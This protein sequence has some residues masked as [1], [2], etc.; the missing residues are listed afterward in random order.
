MVVSLSCGDPKTQEELELKSHTGSDG[1]DKML[2]IGTRWG[3]GLLMCVS[4]MAA[5]GQ[6]NGGT[7]TTLEEI[8]VT[9]QKREQDLRE[10][11]LAVSTLSGDAISALSLVDGKELANHLPGLSWA[12][13]ISKP[14][15][16]IRGVGNND[17]QSSSHNP[18]SLYAD[19]VLLGSS[20]G[21]SNIMFDL[22]RVEVLKGPQGTLWGR[23]TTAGLINF[24]PR[25]AEIGGE[26]SGSVSATGGSFSFREFDSAV[27][28][29]LSENSAIR[30]AYKHSERDG[31]Y[32][33]VNP[34]Y[35]FST[36]AWNWTAGRINFRSQLTDTTILDITGYWG[37]LENE[38]IP[39]KNLG[40]VGDCPNPGVVGTTCGDRDGFVN[41]PD[42]YE[43]GNGFETFERVNRSGVAA[44][45]EWEFDRSVLT[46]ISAF[47]SA[48]RKALQDNDGSPSILSE[49]N[50][51][52]DFSSFSQ[53]FRLTSA[54]DTAV[55]WIIGVYYYSDALEWY[56]SSVRDTGASGA[57]YQDISNETVAGFAEATWSV[58]PVFDLTAGVRLTYDERT[59]DLVRTFVY[60]SQHAEFNSQERAL[61][62]PLGP[63]NIT[64]SGFSRDWT[65]WSGRLSALYRVTDTTNLWLTIA[66][67]FK[68]GD[69][70]SGAF[71]AGEFNISDPEFVTSY[72]IGFKSLSGSDRLRISGSFYYL[73]YTDKQ[74]F[75]EVPGD[76]DIIVNLTTLSNAAEL[77]ISGLDLQ[78]DWQIS[79]KLTWSFGA[80]Y[81]DAEF[82]EFISPGNGV[83]LSGNVTAQTPEYT[84]NT[85]LRHES[86]VSN[87]G[88]VGLQLDAFYRDQVFFTNDN[89][90]LAQQ[91]GYWLVGANAT[92]T[93]PGEHWYVRAWGKNLANEEYFTSGFN[94]SFRGAILLAVGEPRSYGITFGVNF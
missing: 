49:G 92:Y 29:P 76:G 79:D 43:V 22:D 37:N 8:V 48:D 33:S 47:N 36:G 82:I 74:V 89:D 26:L 32:D 6:E 41:T 12:G 35:P 5:V 7:S 18:V 31:P 11:P 9:A 78:G 57:R 84:L 58:T 24:V 68:G 83:D 80:N 17:F 73:D 13:A 59:A 93:A 21:V 20:F 94:F 71:T 85:M 45:F 42:V 1:G 4:W 52:D 72:E 14:S 19:G 81:T 90:P 87:G 46:S 75:T 10:I 54:E 28:A 64:V 50:F 2:R 65:E 30:F 23:N 91:D 3:V 86:V 69:A 88:S 55:P 40:V 67:G 34:D 27:G 56:R 38:P 66:R 25:K 63:D 39:N 16:F 53:E 60:A 61:A 15:I 77:D 62:N 51:Q 44:S 70:N